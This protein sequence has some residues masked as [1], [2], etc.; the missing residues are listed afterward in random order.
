ML[1]GILIL[2]YCVGVGLGILLFLA[3]KEVSRRQRQLAD[4]LGVVEE[5]IIEL[6]S[7]KPDPSGQ[8]S[9]GVSGG[10]TETWPDTSGFSFSEGVPPLDAE[11]IEQ[12]DL[13]VVEDEREKQIF[14]RDKQ[15]ISPEEIARQTGYGVGEVNLVLSLRRRTGK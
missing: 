4:R 11:E 1:L 13:L 6:S 7:E 12:S 3:L 14:N 8:E 15:G 9:Q 5:L 2:L 10:I